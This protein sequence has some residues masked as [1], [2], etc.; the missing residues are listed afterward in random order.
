[1]DNSSQQF[2]T[3]INIEMTIVNRMISDR[4]CKLITET[5]P[6]V[7]AEY[8]WEINEYK[9]YLKRLASYALPIQ[10]TLF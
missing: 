7:L 10:G 6:E 1:M 2:G 5:D 3:C 8:Q 9:D 4:E